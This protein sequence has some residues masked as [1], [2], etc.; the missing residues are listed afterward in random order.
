MFSDYYFLRS[1]YFLIQIAYKFTKL[2]VSDSE[3]NIFCL[4][5]WLS[6]NTGPQFVPAQFSSSLDQRARI[7]SFFFK[8]KLK[9]KFFYIH[10]HLLNKTSKT[11]W[12][13]PCSFCTH[14]RFDEKLAVNKINNRPNRSMQ[15]VIKISSM[16]NGKQSMKLQNERFRDIFNFYF[17]LP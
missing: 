6:F 14:L 16:K 3:P 10:Y 2:V 15:A 8:C 1:L 5:V 12:Y 13:R 17:K 4:F 7:F 9:I 11:S